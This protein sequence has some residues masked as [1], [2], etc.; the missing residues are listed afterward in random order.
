MQPRVRSATPADVPGVRRV[1]SRGWRAAYGDIMSAETV[2]EALSEH[3]TPAEVERAVTA[4]DAVYLFAVAGGRVI[5]YTSGSNSEHGPGAEL[6]TIYVDPDWWGEG[7]GTALFDELRA[8]LRQ[9]GFERVRAVVLAEN[10]AGLPFYRRH[11][12]EQ[13]DEHEEVVGDESHRALVVA[14]EL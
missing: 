2:E 9:R 7:V 13:V 8:R 14:R 6:G 11:G 12:F 5:G 10:E 4:E 3:Y 1:A